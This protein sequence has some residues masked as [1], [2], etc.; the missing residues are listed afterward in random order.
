M[1][2]QFFHGLNSRNNFIDSI[3]NFFG[4]VLGPKYNGKYLH[5]LTN[6]LLGDLTIKETLANVIIPAF[7][8]KLLQPVIFST[9]D[10]C[11]LHIDYQN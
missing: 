11:I 1:G 4:A 7:D 10:V 8:I 9:D 3:T 5:E 6:Q 2:F